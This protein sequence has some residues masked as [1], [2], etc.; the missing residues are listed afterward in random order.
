[1][2]NFEEFNDEWH[3]EAKKLVA[4]Y[5]FRLREIHQIEIQ[6][7]IWKTKDSYGGS[8]FMFDQSHYLHTPVQIDAYRTSVPFGETEEH[9]LR[10]ALDTFKDFIPAAIAKGYT[11]SAEWLEKNETF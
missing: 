10:R 3:F 8:Y 11:P 4:E 2:A 5:S 1:M 7:K 9:A 6:I